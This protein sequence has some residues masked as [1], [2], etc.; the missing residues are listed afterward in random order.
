[1]DQWYDLTMPSSD[2]YVIRNAGQAK[3]GEPHEPP[4]VPDIPP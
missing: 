1:M 3:Q 2:G 4:R